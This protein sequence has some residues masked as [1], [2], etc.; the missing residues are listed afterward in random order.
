MILQDSPSSYDS[1]MRH[2]VV[3]FLYSFAK[4]PQWLNLI[5]VTHVTRPLRMSFIFQIRF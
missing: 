2:L 5:H 1:A 3:L 4:T